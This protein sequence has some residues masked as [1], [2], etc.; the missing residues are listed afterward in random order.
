MFCMVFGISLVLLAYVLSET[1]NDSYDGDKAE[2]KHCQ[3]HYISHRYV[4][5]RVSRRGLPKS[6]IELDGSS[7]A[8][9]LTRGGGGGGGGRIGC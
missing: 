1:E 7:G 8:A 3:G 5:S 9:P 4:T 2:V 6:G